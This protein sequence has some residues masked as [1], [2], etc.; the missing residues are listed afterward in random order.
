VD[1]STVA[2]LFTEYRFA[3]FP[4]QYITHS[5]DCLLNVP[6]FHTFV[7]RF[8]KTNRCWHLISYAGDGGS[9]LNSHFGINLEKSRFDRAFASTYCYCFEGN[10]M[11]KLR[12]SVRSRTSQWNCLMKS[13]CDGHH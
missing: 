3:V 9:L 10:S 7:F 11:K 2:F 4:Y 8:L 5:L 1:Y 12:L 13:A 6:M